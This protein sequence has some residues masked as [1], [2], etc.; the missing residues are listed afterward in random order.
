[1]G[2][3]GSHVAGWALDMGTHRKRIAAGKAR[4]GKHGANQ[5]VGN[6]EH[7]AMARFMRIVRRVSLL[8]ENG[9]HGVVYVRSVFNASAA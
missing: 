2:K 4:F 5:H 7:K 1:M 3:H 6:V 9:K 8:P